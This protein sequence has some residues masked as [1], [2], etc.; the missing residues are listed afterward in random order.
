MGSADEVIVD[1]EGGK[2]TARFFENSRSMFED[3]KNRIW[4]TTN[5]KGIASYSAKSGALKY[6]GENDGLA[7]N[8]A[9]CILEDDN[10]DLWVSTSNGLSRFDT[11][12]D[13]FQNF[14]TNDGLSNNQFCY[15]AA[16]KTLSYIHI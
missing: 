1:N 3:S 4:I 6:Y 8:Q 13:F 15:G 16:Y 9:L 10:H 12:E 14:T 7:N 11:Q 2:S 5:D